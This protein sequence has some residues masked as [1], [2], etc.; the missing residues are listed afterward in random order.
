MF[1]VGDTLEQC[2]NAVGAVAN[3]WLD[4]LDRQGADLPDAE[5]FELLS[6]TKSMSQ[7]GRSPLTPG[8][9]LAS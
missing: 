4:V 2:Y 5:V 9:L 6:E 8:D 7:V 3:R 1:L